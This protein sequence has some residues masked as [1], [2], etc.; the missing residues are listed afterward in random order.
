MSAFLKTLFG[1]PGT[2]AVV[3]IVMAAEVSAAASG[4]PAAAAFAVPALVLAG[5]AWLASR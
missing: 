4:Y 5:T 1:D 3:M 2:V